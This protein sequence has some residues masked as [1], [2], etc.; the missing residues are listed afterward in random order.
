MP[1]TRM[2]LHLTIENLIVRNFRL[3]TP[4]R[5]AQ[6]ITLA[7]SAQNLHHSFAGLII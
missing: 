6:I 1:C 4:H 3:D 7:I 2:F 5:H